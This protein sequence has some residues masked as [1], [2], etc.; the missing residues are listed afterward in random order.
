MDLVRIGAKG[1]EEELAEWL[2]W[3]ETYSE[4]LNLK[5]TLH[6]SAALRLFIGWLGT[7]DTVPSISDFSRKHIRS[8]TV[9]EAN[10]FRRYLLS[11]DCIIKYTVGQ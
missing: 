11:Y 9:P 1:K 4:S 2:Q 7:L 10:T 6:V 5:K 8:D 3:I